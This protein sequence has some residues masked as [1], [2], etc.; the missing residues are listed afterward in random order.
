VEEKKS[1]IPKFQAWWQLYRPTELSDIGNQSLVQKGD[2]RIDLV[3]EKKN[4][5]A[6]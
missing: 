1:F 4:P 2:S 5:K 3:N 6:F